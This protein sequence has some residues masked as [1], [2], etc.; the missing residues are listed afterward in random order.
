[1]SV[2]IA[3]LDG[4]INKSRDARE[5]KRALCVKM[6]LGALPV[7][8]ICEL[9]N[10]SAPFVSK[11]RGIYEAQGAAALGVGY[12]GSQGYLTKVQKGEV[13]AWIQAQP[14][15]T[16]AGVR[17][18]LQEQYEVVYQSP[19][20]Y[21]DLLH[22][23]GLSYHKSEKVNPKRDETLVQER[24]EVIKKTLAALEGDRAG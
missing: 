22:A 3:E 9:L 20:S 15:V 5:V 1:M 2:S 10:V 23:A 21:Y 13:I 12:A 7:A 24:R 8:Q 14:V 19:Q 18:Y 11:W 4:I 16:V 17:D 6:V